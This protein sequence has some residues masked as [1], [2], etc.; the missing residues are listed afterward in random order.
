MLNL[1][2]Y[3]FQEMLK[4]VQH[5][6]EKTRLLDSRLRGNDIEYFYNN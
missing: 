3:L 1:F 4:Q 2:Q 5:D 6:K